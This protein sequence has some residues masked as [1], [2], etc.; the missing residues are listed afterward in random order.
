MATT[1]S[2]IALRVSVTET[3]RNTYLRELTWY[4]NGVKINP[5][6]NTRLNL[7]SD[8]TSLSISSVTDSDSGHYSVQYDGL[9]RYPYDSGCERQTLDLFRHYPLLAPAVLYLS[10]NGEFSSIRQSPSVI[11]KQLFN[12]TTTTVELAVYVDCLTTNEYQ[13]YFFWLFNGNSFFSLFS[14]RHK[15]TLYSQQAKLYVDNPSL[16]DAGVYETLL[17]T[18]T[19]SKLT[20]DNPFPYTWFMG[21]NYV[22]IRS[23]IQQLLYYGNLFQFNF[24]IIIIM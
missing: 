2:D 19:Y 5:T 24:V 11:R 22:I 20:C 21:T 3:D 12:E 23:D 4:H 13:N 6:S 9:R 16:L 10:T 14:K 8:N 7:T 1:G 17:W 18:T 15:T